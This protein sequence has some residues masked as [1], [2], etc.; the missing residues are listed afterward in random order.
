MIKLVIVIESL[1]AIFSMAW[2]HFVFR[3]FNNF[4]KKI[5]IAS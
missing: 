5:K 4:K 2:M 1:I 3:V